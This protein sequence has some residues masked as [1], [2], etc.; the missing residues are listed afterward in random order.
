MK[1]EILGFNQEKVVELGLSVNDL[2]LLNYIT[3]AIASPTMQHRVQDGIAYV[4]LKHD[5][6]LQD[7]PI[8][9]IKERSLINYL[10]KLK[11]LGLL[12][13]CVIKIDCN[14]GGKSY[15]AITEKCEALKYDQLQKIAL[16]Q[17]PTAKNCT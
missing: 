11:D 4:W 3:D 8:L 13:V 15:Y 7:L 6:I 1:F 16:N 9:D 10:N 17:R 14:R 5:R 12:S 2:I